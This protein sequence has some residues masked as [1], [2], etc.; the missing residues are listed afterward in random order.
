MSQWREA[1]THTHK[2]TEWSHACPRTAVFLVQHP[3]TLGSYWPFRCRARRWLFI[4]ILFGVAVGWLRCG[5]DR[6]SL[7]GHKWPHYPVP[8]ATLCYWQAAPICIASCTF[9]FFSELASFQIRP[10]DSRDADIFVKCWFVLSGSESRCV[11]QA[12][13]PLG[14]FSASAFLMLG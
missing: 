13:L 12:S 11:A 9:S 14:N 3:T 1:A 7:P 2:D 10:T 5:L 8:V 4:P 6:P